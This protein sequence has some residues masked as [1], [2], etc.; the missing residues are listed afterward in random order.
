MVNNFKNIQFYKCSYF[1]LFPN[2]YQE[3]MVL[4]RDVSITNWNR[5]GPSITN[6]TLYEWTQGPSES[7]SPSC[8]PSC[9]V[10]VVNN[11]TKCVKYKTLIGVIV[12]LRSLQDIYSFFN[13]CAGHK[14]ANLLKRKRK[15]LSSLPFP[16]YYLKLTT[17]E[18]LRK[19]QR[20]KYL[21]QYIF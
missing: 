14:C 1:L 15:I 12:C 10:V 16:A 21:Q 11:R 4:T 8:V 13:S 18:N 6:T 2:C 20:T 19:S 5:N 17:K 7:Q 3:L 9:S